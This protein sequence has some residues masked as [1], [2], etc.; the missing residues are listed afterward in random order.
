MRTCVGLFACISV[1]Q[2]SWTYSLTS[3]GIQSRFLLACKYVAHA[4]APALTNKWVSS[5][6]TC[7]P[8]T[9]Q[10]SD[11]TKEE[12]NVLKLTVDVDFLRVFL[13]QL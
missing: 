12:L 3:P 1:I 2:R 6:T 5:A 13:K 7:E 4:A 10:F 9:V 11:L 8:I